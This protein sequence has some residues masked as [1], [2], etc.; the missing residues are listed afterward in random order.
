MTE[1]LIEQLRRDGLL[2][3]DDLGLGL[4]VDE[5]YALISRQGSASRVLHYV[6]PFLKAQNWEATAVP[7]LRKHASLLAERLS[8]RLVAQRQPVG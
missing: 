1:P 5:N 3:P 8:A 6:G 2:C 7:E 4:Q